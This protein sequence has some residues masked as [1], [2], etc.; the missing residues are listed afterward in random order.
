MNAPPIVNK[1]Q[2]R[3]K[4][5]DD[6]AVLLEDMSRAKLRDVTHIKNSKQVFHLPQYDKVIYSLEE[7]SF[8]F[9]DIGE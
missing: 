1:E 6:V 5:D 4:R 2:Q 3:D 7:R 9:T 8:T